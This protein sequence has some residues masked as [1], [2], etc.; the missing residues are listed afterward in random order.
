V[1]AETIDETTL[2]RLWG[3]DL[4]QIKPEVKAIILSALRK[5]RERRKRNQTLVARDSLVQP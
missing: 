2:E 1:G 3:A 5:A 4:N